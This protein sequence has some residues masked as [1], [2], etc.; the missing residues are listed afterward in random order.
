[1]RHLRVHFRSLIQNEPRHRRPI[2]CPFVPLFSLK[3]RLSSVH[4]TASSRLF[5]VI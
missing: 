1:M 5:I 4:E 3:R 2:Y